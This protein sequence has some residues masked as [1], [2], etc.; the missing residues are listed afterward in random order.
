MGHEFAFHDDNTRPAPFQLLWT[1]CGVT[2]FAVESCSVF[3]AVSC[4][5]C[6]C[7]RSTMTP[8]TLAMLKTALTVTTWMAA[9]FPS[10]TRRWVFGGCIFLPELGGLK[11]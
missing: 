4:L 5:C 10:C 7:R 11:F 3:R 6:R 1:L 8:V 2:G 9:T